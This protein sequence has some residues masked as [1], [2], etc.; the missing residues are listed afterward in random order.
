MTNKPQGLPAIVE[1]MAPEIQKSL[2]TQVPAE[3]FIRAFQTTVNGD[4]NINK[5]DRTSVLKAV[6]QAAQDGLVI[7]NKEA[8]I[9]PF[10]GKAVYIPMVAGVIK[11]MR[12]HSDFGTLSHGIIYLNEVEQGR[13]I[14]EKGDDE[15]I[16]HSPILFEDR[17]EPIGAYAVVTMKNGE[18]FRS[19]LRK[20]AIVKRLEVGFNSAAKKD[21]QEE[22][23]IKTVIKDVAKRAPNSG[24][25]QGY[26]DGVFSSEDGTK[27][28]SDGVVIP[29]EPEITEPKG[30][31]ASA[32]VMAQADEIED[33]EIIPDYDDDIP[34]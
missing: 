27:H 9:I 34:M 21:W 15:K 12:Q 17:G 19:V 20:E 18:R 6:M 14:Y 4:P 22:F 31:R 13:F 10:K 25:E 16:Y 33:A 7:D 28:D 24:D 30:T 8:A 3:R 11:K 32:A 1:K 23:W 2:G 5:L 26:M 29:D